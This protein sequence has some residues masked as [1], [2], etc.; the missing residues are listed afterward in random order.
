MV[1]GLQPTRAKLYIS[2]HPDLGLRETPL[3]RLETHFCQW[4]SPR[5]SLDCGGT[6]TTHL[7]STFVCWKHSARRL[8]TLSEWS[9]TWSGEG[10]ETHLMLYRAIDRSKFDYCCIV[11]ATTSNTNLRQLDIHKSG[12]R[13]ELGEFCTCPVS[14]LYT[15]IKDVLWRNVA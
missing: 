13:L 11:Y 8:S 7:R 9:L 12:L 5:S 14:S 2:L 6:R 1:S 4:R 3:W 10:T 15:E